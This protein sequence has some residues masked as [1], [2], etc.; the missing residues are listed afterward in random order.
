MKKY[1]TAQ[2]LKQIMEERN[3][4]QV[5]ILRLAEP[6]SKKYNIKLNKN[7][8][9]QYV[10]GKVTPGQDK[11]FILGLALNVSEVWLMGYDDVER[12]RTSNKI[13]D[14]FKPHYIPYEIRETVKAQNRKIVADENY[15]L[16]ERVRAEIKVIGCLFSRSIEF[17]EF[18]P[19][20]VPFGEYV[21]LYLGQASTKSRLP[22]DVYSSLAIKFGTKPG[23]KE[24]TTY[25]FVDDSKTPG[26]RIDELRY[27]AYQELDGE[28]DEVVKDVIKFIKFAKALNRKEKDN[29]K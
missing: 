19:N 27:A 28:S 8:L 24:G 9:S 5:D 22:D 13:P 12:N 20:H 26:V 25:A 3:I 11:L 4:K 2:R 29:T 7:D 18:S 16:E 1:T 14:T 23:M 17:A 15:P 6:F 10:N 21:A